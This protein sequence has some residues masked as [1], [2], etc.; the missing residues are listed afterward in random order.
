MIAWVDKGKT[1]IIIYTQD[2][3]NEVDTFLSENNFHLLPNSPTHK[4]HKTIYKTQ[5]KCDK[6]TDKSTSNT[7][8]KKPIPAYTW[9]P[10]E[11]AQT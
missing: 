9:C 5:Q 2:Y 8:L 6:I 11:T 7:W 10:T 4:D 3:T 1:T